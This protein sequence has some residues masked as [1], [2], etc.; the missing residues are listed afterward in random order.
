MGFSVCISLV[1]IR[2]SLAN[3]PGD[4]KCTPAP[5]PTN[6]RQEFLIVLE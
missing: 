5:G 3:T 2:V 4:T 6:L 1:Y